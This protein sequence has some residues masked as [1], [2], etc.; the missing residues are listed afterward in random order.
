MKPGQEKRGEA[1]TVTLQFRVAFDEK[2]ES[3]IESALYAFDPRGKLLASSP[4]KADQ[5]QLQLTEE[6][7]R[8]AR[9]F[10][11]PASRVNEEKLP[12]LA[13][14]KRLGAYEPVWKFNPQGRVQELAPIPSGVWKIW[15]ICRCRV[16]G[17]VVKRVSVGGTTQ[18]L[19]VPMARVHICE[20]DA[21]PRLILK[22]PDSAIYR[23]RDELLQA[24]ERIPIPEPIPQPDPPPFLNPGVIDPV[25]DVIRQLSGFDRVALNPQPLPPRLTT[26]I[27]QRL[28]P[29]EAVGFNPQPDPPRDPLV[30]VLRRNALQT[31]ALNP[32][33]LPPGGAVGFD[34][35][36]EPPFLAGLAAL[37]VATRSALLSQSSQLLRTTIAAQLDLFR[38]WLCSWRWFWSWFTCDELAVVDTDAQGRFDVP[39]WYPCFGDH[40]DLYFWV[41]YNLGGVMTTVYHP[42]IPCHVYWN[43]PC[44]TEVTIRIT[45]PRVPTAP[46]PV[47][48]AGTKVHVIRNGY[49]YV[50]QIT[51][52]GL[53]VNNAPFGGVIR[54]YVEFAATELAAAGI[55]HYRWSYQRLTL[56]NGTTPVTDTWHVM[57]NT[58]HRHYT[59]IAGDGTWSIKPFL[60]G[61]DPAIG[62]T[63][64]FQ[65]QPQNP[66]LLAGS[67]NGWWSLYSMPDDEVSAYFNSAAADAFGEDFVAGKF[68]LKLELFRIVGGAPVLATLPRDG[69]VIPPNPPISGGVITPVQAPDAM[70]DLDGS[71]NVLAFHFTLRVDNNPCVASIHDTEVNGNAAGPCGMITFTPGSSAQMAFLAY[72]PHDFANFSFSTIKGSSGAV[73]AA[74][75][76]QTAVDAPSANGFVRNP[77]TG[78]FAKNV[79]VATLLGAC[80]QAA[81]AEHLYVEATATDGYSP[82]WYLNRGDTKAFALTTS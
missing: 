79:P 30:S 38:P 18:D 57:D 7:A 43:Y 2:P 72:H 13:T 37:P 67:L 11:A 74:T 5:A 53:T 51:P 69:F 21:W 42:P 52:D 4:L 59:E 47:T 27:G 76:G 29:G 19:A 56:G 36:P 8:F 24:L 39:I 50:S 80:P 1:Q 77:V 63:A 70:V 35:Q 66:P 48:L 26:R 54:P 23:L 45:D 41:E 78:V 16:R 65:I 6:Q 10:V 22:L 14:M 82:L 31:V 58:V 46:P 75:I 61:P 68:K 17:Q 20:V 62:S 34:P 60:L 32:Q 64:L 73:A 33:P 25:P 71:G 55:T 15:P 3:E 9:L 40:P 12:T 49:H 28:S 44:G 81:F